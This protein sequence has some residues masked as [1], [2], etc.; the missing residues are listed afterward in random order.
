[1]GSLRAVLLS[2]PDQKVVAVL[3]RAY[4][5]HFLRENPSKR[6][7]LLISERLDQ[8]YR[9]Q[10]L[11]REEG[12]VTVEQ[13]NGWLDTLESQGFFETLREEYGLE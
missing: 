13:V 9:H 6:E 11:I 2:E 4:V 7:L 12:P 3:P 10:I 1:M 5:H 8:R